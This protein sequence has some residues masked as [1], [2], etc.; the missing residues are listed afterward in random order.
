VPFFSYLID[1]IGYT[2]LGYLSP[3]FDWCTPNTTFILNIGLERPLYLDWIQ[4][5]KA[6][7]CYIYSVHLQCTFTVYIY[8]VHLQCTFTVYIYSVHLQCTM[9]L[10]LVHVEAGWVVSV[11]PGAFWTCFAIMNRW[12]SVLHVACWFTHPLRN[13]IRLCNAEPVV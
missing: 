9:S 10:H 1:E 2:D 13:L 7:S 11:Y 4:F 6:Q 8:S 3:N 12:T 5:S